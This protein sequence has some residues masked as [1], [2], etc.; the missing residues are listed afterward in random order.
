MK[1]FTCKPDLRKKRAGDIEAV[2]SD[3][4]LHSHSEDPYK[5]GLKAATVELIIK[6]KVGVRFQL[7]YL[8]T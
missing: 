3:S 2:G 6:T 7:Y 1:L 8:R 4:V 5:E